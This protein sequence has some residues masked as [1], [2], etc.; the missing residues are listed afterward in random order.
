M[1]DEFLTKG[2]QND[3]YLKAIQLIEQFEDEIEATLRRFGQRMVDEHPKLFATDPD[4]NER[5]NRSPGSALAHTRVNYPMSGLRAR[6]TDQTW[7][8]NVHLYWVDPAQ[9]DR[10][11]V[12][13]ALRAFGYKVKHASEDIDREVVRETRAKNWSLDMSTNPYDSNIA[14]YK[15]VSSAA[16]MEE[17]A[18]TLVQHFRTFGDEYAVNSEK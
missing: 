18:D 5:T 1:T 8:L 4:G 14:F 11:D 7:Q 13:G 12:D 10:T 6:D 2:L 16:E 15:H 17:T 3:R 9:Y